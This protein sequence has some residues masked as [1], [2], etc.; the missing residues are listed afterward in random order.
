MKLMVLVLNKTE[1]LNELLEGLLDIGIRGATVIDSTGMGRILSTHV[2]LIGGLSHLFD[3]DRPANKVVFSIIEN[4]KKLQQAVELTHK[5][6]GNLSEPGTGVLFTL[7]LDQVVG[8][9]G[10]ISSD[11]PEDSAG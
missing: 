8:L 3:G 1:E 11:S 9:A 10:N 6:V 5:I 4:D 2:P 7:Q